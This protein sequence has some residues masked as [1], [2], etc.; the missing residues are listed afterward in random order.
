MIRRTNKLLST[1]IISV[2][3]DD[4]ALGLILKSLLMQSVTNFEVI[5]SEDGESDEIKHCADRFKSKDILLLHL[6]Q[7]DKGFRKNIALNRAIKASNTEHLIFIDGDCVPHPSF[8]EAHQACT[9]RGIICTGRRLELGEGISDNL[10]TEKIDLSYLTNRLQYLLHCYALLKDNA[11]N[12]ESG[13]YS[14]ALQNLTEGREIR[15]LGC[16]F[17][18]NKQD[19]IKI[20]GFNEDYLAPGIGEDSDIDWR[21]LKSGV[22][23][24]NV[25]FSAIQYHLYHPRAYSTSTENMALFEETKQSNDYTCRHG[26]EHITN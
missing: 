16:N 26:L 8:V 19:L 13:I 10:R 23:I 21:L 2:Y 17:S 14:K 18:S 9:R 20:N 4:V 6:R 3:K 1:V 7:E 24:R 15:V 5:V 12:I 22:K 25:K 11:K